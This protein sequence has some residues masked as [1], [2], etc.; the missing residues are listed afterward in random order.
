VVRGQSSL[1]RK[2]LRDLSRAGLHPG[3]D[4]GPAGDTGTRGQLHW[5]AGSAEFG[6]KENGSRLTAERFTF[7]F[8][9][10]GWG[11]VA[12]ACNPSCREAEIER[13]KFEVKQTVCE[14][15]P[16][17]IKAGVIVRS[18]HPSYSLSMNRRIHLGLPCK[19]V[20]PYWKK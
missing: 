5:C 1:S 10:L 2:R 6:F 11:E 20:T 12:H 13:I 18:F 8:V 17:P 4:L 9:H 7:R 16:Q 15:P 19:L 14:T 3:R